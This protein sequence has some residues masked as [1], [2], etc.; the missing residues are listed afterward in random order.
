MRRIF[1]ALALLSLLLALM[2]A[3]L[4]LRSTR[5]ATDMVTINAGPRSGHLWSLDGWLVLGVGR[6]TPGGPRLAIESDGPRPDGISE[7]VVET[8]LNDLLAYETSPG[9]VI[10]GMHCR[11][12]LFVLTLLPAAWGLRH[13][14]KTK[15]AGATPS[16]SP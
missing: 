6:S 8:R 14:R 7:V 2:V 10:M 16:S 3:G 1:N 12:A 15:Q 4:W 13:V 11:L 5:W 9:A